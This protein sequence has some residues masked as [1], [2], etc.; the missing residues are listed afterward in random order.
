MVTI[1]AVLDGREVRRDEVLS[2]EQRRAET[3]LRKLGASVRSSDGIGLRRAHVERK[4]ELGHEGIERLLGRELRAAEVVGRVGAALSSGRRRLC[5][6]ELT[7]RGA[8]VETLP[9]WYRQTI[10]ANNE[11]PLIEACPD[12]YISRTRIGG[13]QEVIETTGGS[14]MPVRMFF[15]DED[16]STLRSKPDPAFPVEWTSVA[17]SASGAPIG[18]VRHLFRDEADGFRVR[19]AVEFPLTTPPSMIRQHRWHLA[20]EFSNW[21]ETTSTT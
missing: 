17:R 18:G 12:H 16:V 5:T 4:L 21:I 7:G 8:S 10:S 9:A 19:L 20:C 1:T 15:D 11:V 6:I 3:V 14:P 13:G 2:W